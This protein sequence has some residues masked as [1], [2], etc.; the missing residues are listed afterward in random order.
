MPPELQQF[1]E[2]LGA[3]RAVV[4]HEHPE[5]LLNGALLSAAPCFASRLIPSALATGFR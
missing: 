2:G 1:R 5:G 4:H 3:G